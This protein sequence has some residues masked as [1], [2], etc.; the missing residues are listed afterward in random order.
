M[1]PLVHRL[2]EGSDRGSNPEYN[3][4]LRSERWKILSRAVQMRARGKCEICKRADGRECAH[5][6]YDRVFNEPMSDLLWLCVRCHRDL[7]TE[8]RRLRNVVE[9][10]SHPDGS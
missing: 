1:S 2:G 9:S 8:R 10:T 6:T 4:Y 3:E 5:L 7:D